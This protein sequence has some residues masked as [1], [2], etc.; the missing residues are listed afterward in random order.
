MENELEIIS[1]K[2]HDE[3]E[4]LYGKLNMSPSSE[5]QLKTSRQHYV[6]RCYLHLWRDNS[7][8]LYQLIN[9]EIVTARGE[10]KVIAQ[11]KD[12]YRVKLLSDTEFRMLESAI[13]SYEYA[14]EALQDFTL[15]YLKIYDLSGKVHESFSTIPQLLPVTDVLVN[16]LVEKL[17]AEIE[18]K[19][20]PILKDMA[21][22]NMDW[23]NDCGK[24]VDFYTFW[25]TQYTRTPGILE[26][27]KTVPLPAGT[28]DAVYPPMM[29]HL[30][31]TIVDM[32]IAKAEEYHVELLKNNSTLPFITGDRPII[33]LCKNKDQK[34]DMYF[35]VSPRYALRIK[36]TDNETPINPEVTETHVEEFNQAIKRNCRFL[37][38]ADRQ[39]LEKYK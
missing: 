25:G 37:Y 17:Y 13:H 39:V 31:M 20:A 23:W 35:P 4:R 36:N 8:T 30:A 15:F 34:L 11:S 2:L 6:P 16:N 24:R 38:A 27:A 9:G 29:M 5:L 14:N 26:Q 21:T 22:G 19:A 7:D 10:L 18:G 1:K 3:L 33:D 28:T 12:F 32:M